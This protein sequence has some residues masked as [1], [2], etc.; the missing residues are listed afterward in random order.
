MTVAA[1]DHT[2][3]P[4]A[5]FSAR[6]TAEGT[7]AVVAF[8]G[9]A[10]AFTLP[11]VIDALVRV[12]SEH[13]GP[14]VVDLAETSFIDTGTLRAFGRAALILACRDRSLTV[15]APSRMA[16]RLLAF[17]GLSDLIQIEPKR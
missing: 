11:T 3:R 8:R 6:V 14:V 7:A 15:R 17:L 1:L 5:P 16:L 9:E 13:D 2:K 10:D 12:I 4:V